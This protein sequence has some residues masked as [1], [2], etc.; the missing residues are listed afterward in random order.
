MVRELAA[1]VLGQYSPAVEEVEPEAAE[2]LREEIVELQEEAQR[3][4]VQKTLGP[5]MVTWLR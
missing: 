5:V 4:A 1:A 2:Q 3:A